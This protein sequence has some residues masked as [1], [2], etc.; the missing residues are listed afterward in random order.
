MIRPLPGILPIAGLFFGF[1]GW[2]AAADGLPRGA[3]EMPYVR[4]EAEAGSR[5]GGATERA[6][7]DFDVSKTASEASGR[8]Y[9][10][11]SANGSF[12]E[13]VVAG[14]AD[15]ATMRFTLPDNAAGTGVSGSLAVMVNGV[16]VMTVYPGSYWAWTYFQSTD[17][18]NA[19]GAR[20]RM[21]FD[22]LHFRLPVGLQAGD[23][24]RIAKTNGDAYEYGID[25]VELEPVP[26]ALGKP[27]GFVSVTDYGAGGA[28][29]L[30]DSS[31]FDSAWQAAKNAGTGLYIPE[32]KFV[33][34]RRWNLGDSTNIKIQGAGIWF[35]EIF[36]SRKAV[37]AGGF[38]AGENTT[39]IDI[40]HFYMNSA[41]N[42]R[43]IVAGQVSDYK[44]FNGPLGSGSTIHDVWV[45]HFEAGV[46]LADYTSPVRV[47]SGFELSRSRFRG[48]Y[49]D[50]VNFTQ[51]SHS[52][53]VS[54]CDF[55]D[56]GDDAM[57][58]WT[59]STAGA[60]QGHDVIFRNN[61]V[62]F[63]YRA[64]DVG[65]FGGYG[66]QVH[67]NIFK[68]GVDSSGIRFTEDFGGY[69]FAAN[70]SIR[71]FEN[72]I[73]G[74]GTSRD[75]WNNSRGAIEINGAGIR[76]LFFDGN[77]VRDSPRHAIQIDGGT[78]LKFTNTIIENTGLD[79]FGPPGGAAIHEFGRG[80]SATFTGLVLSGIESDPAVLQFNPDYAL[81]VLS[82]VPVVS[83]SSVSVREGGSSGFSVSLDSEPDAEVV[84]TVQRVA[85]DADLAVVSGS[86]LT[87]DQTNWFLPQNVGLAAAEDEDQAAGTAQFVISADR[88][89]NATV[90][91]TEIDNDVN[92]APLPAPDAALT[93]EGVD[94]AVDVLAN[95]VEIDGDPLTVVAAT[96]GTGGSV[97]HNGTHVFY[98]P[99][100]GFHGDDFFLYSV[101]DGRG[102][103]AEARVDV[104][105][106]DVVEQTPYAMEIRFDGYT[107]AET[108][109]DFPVL[110]R[111]G[112]Q[113]AGFSY[114]QFVAPDGS[115]LRFHDADRSELRYEV[116]K[117]DPLGESLVWVRVPRLAAGTRIWAAWGLPAHVE[118]PA[119]VT[120][121]ETWRNG[122]AGVYHLGEGGSERSDSTGFLRHGT[123]VGG[124]VLAVGV[125]GSA[126]S[127]DGSGDAVDLPANFG[128]FNGASAA[129]VECWFYARAVAPDS[130]WQTSPLL[131]QA[132]GEAQWMITFGDSLPGNTLAARTNQGGWASPASA[133]GVS[134][135][136][137]T[138][139]AVTYSPSG[140]G[141]WK[142]Y[143]DGSLAGSGTRAGM[144]TAE[145]ALK[146][147]VGGSNE[148]GTSRWFN[149]LIDEFRISTSARS[150][151][152]VRASWASVAPGGAFASYQPVEQ[153]TRELSVS[154][155]SGGGAGGSS[156]GSYPDG[157]EA[158]VQATPSPYFLWSHW[159]GDVPEGQE[160]QNPL[161]LTMDRNRSITAI[162]VPEQTRNGTPHW[163]LAGYGSPADFEAASVAD[164]DGDGL[165]AHQEYLAGTNPTD[166]ASALRAS[167]AA[168]PDPTH[169]RM[170]WT[171][172][173]GKSYRVEDTIDLAG[174]WSALQSGIP[175]TPPFNSIDLPIPSGS[176]RFFRV[177]VE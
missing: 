62:E 85:G 126:T 40:S 120:S 71:I 167:L 31:A 37:G 60:P 165:N 33:L 19:P 73:V 77:I 99:D 36:F 4:Y 38:L 161:A 154:A 5:G 24:L 117:W 82:R 149:G 124:P 100:P 138:H 139:C 143:L 20:P 3:H 111:L 21:R 106:R 80:G 29:E 158:I 116:E 87:F 22:E 35:T 101:S 26:P 125:A 8:R 70:S 123:L 16:Q 72:T 52:G 65:I 75:L 153:T 45:A 63:T 170:E 171:S 42:E 159:T 23:V 9:V 164:S 113:I 163:W 47:T 162:F 46:W 81:T 96:A 133:S 11:L 91:A 58:I 59:S 173:S 147:L 30:S 118:R 34:D 32:G 90:T 148:A 13:W 86:S 17:P 67:H 2:A 169:L 48:M 157:A 128:V 177:V 49:A 107:E 134:T 12:V 69:L 109:T 104:V 76:N 83:A 112:T 88:Y 176:S 27:A 135:L 68:D 144:V 79:S 93:S 137:W 119:Y 95:D 94:V 174:D 102:G 97:T 130:T 56:C 129:T 146:N 78:N 44:A 140:T 103:V 64:G 131:F 25:F 61:T 142:I 53:T 54:Q 14:E 145:T 15:G 114:G 50:G 10:G 51:G 155:S 57:A 168:S 132:R 122:F 1:C 172:V 66:H 115:D 156:N 166:P 89:G 136:R 41:L 127:F 110:V 18:R 55:R 108:L 6:A 7:L 74:K 141:N 92:H 151:A 150:A 39:G 152:W 160:T 43:H 175:G 28:D 105:V 98:Q 84:L 121:G